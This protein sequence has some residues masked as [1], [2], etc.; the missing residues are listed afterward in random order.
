MTR[1]RCNPHEILHRKQSKQFINHNTNTM[2]NHYVQDKIATFT[3][4][5]VPTEPMST[6]PSPNPK[7]RTQILTHNTRNQIAW[8]FSSRLRVLFRTT[9]ASYMCSL[10]SILDLS[11]L[12]PA[13]IW[14]KVS[15]QRLQEC[16]GEFRITSADVWLVIHFQ[17]H[18]DEW[19]QF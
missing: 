17:F 12:V 14:N 18:R 5:I 4:N 11:G 15:L 10:N 1:S 13:H 2:S 19:I 3:I 9:L 6:L 8:L 7:S 16:A